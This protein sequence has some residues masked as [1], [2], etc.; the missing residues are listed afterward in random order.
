MGNLNK[1]S[2]K[3][4]STVIIAVVI[5]AVILLNVGLQF[6]PDT[7]K[8]FDITGEKSYTLSDTTKK[9]LSS[10][11]EKVTVYVLDADGSDIKYEYWLDRLDSS[12]KNIDVK[13]TTFDKV[14]DKLTALGVKLESAS[15]YV[16]II[17]SEKRSMVLSYADLITYR[18]NNSDLIS[19]IQKSEMTAEEYNYWLKMFAQYAQSSSEYAS[20]YAQMLQIL[21]YDVEKY[22]NAESY[23]CKI[24][25]YVTVDVIPARYTLTGHGETDFSKTEMGY[26][27]SSVMGKSYAALDMTDGKEIPKDAVSILVIA[28]TADIS[29][30]EA[31]TLIS[32]LEDGGQM[33]FFT[34][35]ANLD[36]PNL[37]SVIRAYGLNAE[38]GVV[39]E[40]VEVAADSAEDTEKKTEYRDSV[41]VDLY[42]KWQ[43][44]IGVEI[45]PVVSGGNS[46]S[47][48][49]KD[50]IEFKHILTSQST[51]IVGESDPVPEPRTLA[52]LSQKKGGGTLLWFTG[53][54]SFTKAILSKEDANNAEIMIPLQSNIYIV[55]AS[56]TLAP[57]TYES[58]VTVPDAKYYGER[59]MSV[60]ETSY[61]LYAVVIIVL[62]VALAIFGVIFWYKRKKA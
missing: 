21:V 17:E 56:L 38:K 28:P 10:L 7:V 62:V 54:E 20:Q 46:I 55:F 3:S 19:I 9:Y 58:T 61:V 4:K 32:F 22:F 14:T 48:E 53:A 26:Q 36:M 29:K 51:Y 47:F 41:A 18:T 13:W 23:L 57:V 39:G 33:T 43:N 34:N 5:A 24:V 31:D 11:D 37:M 15:P 59:L 16:L 40:V 8:R 12:F 2:K 42:E 30:S 60:N 49:N 35:E 27:L 25:E 45:S 50:G 1:V 44:A 52:A 6:L